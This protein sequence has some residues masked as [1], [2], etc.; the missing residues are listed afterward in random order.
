MVNSFPKVPPQIQIFCIITHIKKGTCS[1]TVKHP[2]WPQQHYSTCSSTTSSS[3]S[4][5]S[6]ALLY[7]STETSP[8][9]VPLLQSVVVLLLDLILLLLLLLLVLVLLPRSN[10]YTR[11]FFPGAAVLTSILPWCSRAHVN[12]S[13][14]QP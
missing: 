8:A 10:M 9:L 12:S 4:L 2:S 7:F 6:L 11:Q 5:V 13:L 14:V 3:S 1:V